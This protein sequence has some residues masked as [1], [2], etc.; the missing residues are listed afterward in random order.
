MLRDEVATHRQE[1]ENAKEN[2]RLQREEHIAA[3]ERGTSP[4]L[5]EEQEQP[6]PPPAPTVIA[7]SPSSPHEEEEIPSTQPTIA[8]DSATWRCRYEHLA[9]LL[10]EQARQLK[11]KVRN[12]GRGID[13]QI[14]L[15]AFFSSCVLKLGVAG[16]DAPTKLVGARPGE[17][18]GL[19][20]EQVWCP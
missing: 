9:G 1:A 7:D 15:R 14:N 19:E 10:T 16:R 5:E 3:V 2:L 20:C 18:V 12:E 13:R 11:G 4:A 6:Q 8:D 17:R